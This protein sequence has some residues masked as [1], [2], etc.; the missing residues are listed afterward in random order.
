MRRSFTGGANVPWSRDEISGCECREKS[1]RHVHCPCF[2]CNGRA[3]DRKTE[4]RHWKETCELAATSPASVL[5]NHSDSDSHISEDMFFDDVAGCDQSAED[6]LGIGSDPESLQDLQQRNGIDDNDDTN[7]NQN[8]MKKLVFKAVLDALRIKHK[9]GVSVSTF[10]DVLEYGK[11]LLFT[12]LGDDVDRDILTTLWPKSWNDVQLLLKEEGYEDAKQY[13]ICFCREEK[14]VTRDGK[15]TKKFVYDGKYSVM[16]NKDDRCPHCGNKGY[17]K[18]MYLGLEN[19]LKNWFRN[20]SMCTNML[21]HWLEKEHWLENVESWHL[22]KEIWDGNRWSELQWFW[23]PESVWVLPTRC[24]H[25]NIPISADHLINSPDCDRQGEF[26]IVECPVCFEDFEHCIKM[27]KGS[28]L[29]LALIGHFDGW[30][31]F[32]T[33]YRG[34]GSFEVTVA[35]MRK[36][37]RN[38]VDKVYVVGFVPCFEVPNLPESLDPFLDPLMNDLCNGFIEGFQVN[39]PKGISISGYEPSREETVRVLLLCW[40]A[41]HPGQCETGKFLNQGKCACRRCKLVGQHLENSS[42]TH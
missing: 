21:G 42:N 25:C 19:K 9:S 7:S 41:D 32:G 30:Q 36:T 3:T 13:F 40:T 6:E 14:E 17:I 16:E 35:N 12:S 18:Y 20:K 4:L 37:Q 2:A 33:S 11:T 34:S 10:E 1:Y 31:P 15:S 8:P 27:A 5:N 22:K 38:H 23:N 26:K 24:V 28:P 39:Y 29:N